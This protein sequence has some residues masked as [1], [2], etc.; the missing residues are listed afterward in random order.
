[1][2][3]SYGVNAAKRKLQRRMTARNERCDDCGHVFRPKE[4]RHGGY[5]YSPMVLLCT[6]CADVRAD[7]KYKR[8]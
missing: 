4:L 7:R 6:H 5:Q 8:P 2:K 1:M 3:V